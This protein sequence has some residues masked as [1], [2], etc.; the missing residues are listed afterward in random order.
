MHPQQS[1]AYYVSFVWRVN[2]QMVPQCIAN[3]KQIMKG[4]M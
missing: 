1:K 2:R 3:L 4:I